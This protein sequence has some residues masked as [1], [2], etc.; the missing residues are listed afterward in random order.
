M[1]IGPAAQTV[2]RSPRPY[3]DPI[4]L[5]RNR[6]FLKLWFGQ[7][8]SEIGSRITR[9]GLPLTAVLVLH[10]TPIQ[11]GILSATGGASVLLF[12]L[13]A[14]LIV[15]RV[16]RRPVMILAD[17]SRA[18]LLASV[19][20]LALSHLLS[21]FTLVVIAAS[22][23]V[24]TVLF[25]VAYQSY[26]PSVIGPGQ[27]LE[28][29]RLL[30]ISSATAEIVGPSLT[31]ILVQLVTAPI[32]ILWDAISFLVSGISVWSIYAPEP[33]HLRRAAVSWRKEILLGM[34]TIL[35]HP[36]LRALLF[37]SV[38][39]FLSMGALFSFYIL[40]AIQVLRLSPAALGISIACGGAGSLVG[41]L[42]A[43]RIST[44]L[45]LK[46]SF[47]ISALIIGLAQLLVPAASLTPRFGQLFLCIQQFVGDFAW[48]VYFVNETTLRQSLAPSDLLGR[49]N[50]A[51]QLASRGML[52]IGALAAGFLA[53]S[54]GIVNTLW[55]GV[56]G[57]VLSTL[58]LLPFLKSTEGVKQPP[59]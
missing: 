32:A 20:A 43:G 23:G 37:R 50:A 13:A 27:L 40:Y 24:L 36:A 18:L 59:A 28:G 30:S 52:P 29:N 5:W 34:E 56:A 25:D 2:A 17:F 11:M 26:L 48:T 10:A 22:A 45:R 39:A 15:D 49:V 19:P 3:T 38:T 31:G 51:M 35:A 41:G 1:A 53:A 12:S 46:P 55:I 58:W 6:S 7:T 33:A 57:V 14:G 21:I 54:I 9:E 42:L 44:H 16:R 8:V 4:T 47:F